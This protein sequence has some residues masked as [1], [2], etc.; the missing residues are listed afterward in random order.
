M[1][2]SWVVDVQEDSNGECFIEFPPDLIEEAGWKEHDT[3][4]WSD[5]KD[6]SFTLTKHEDTEWVL[7]ECVDV[8]RIRYMV[9]VPKG[10]TAW[11][12]DTVT[13]EEA[14][15]FS[16]EHI[17]E[18]IMSHRTL[19]R[20]EALKLCNIDNQYASEWTDEHKIKAFFTKKEDYYK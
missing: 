1:S 15:V 18:N 3:I 10:K 12:L 4:V 13:M 2:K 19:S 16:Q 14:Q 7:V 5:N 11:A 8:F 9:E 20:D 17:S 6:G